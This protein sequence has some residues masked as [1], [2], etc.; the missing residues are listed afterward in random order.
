[1]TDTA[2]TEI[3]PGQSLAGGTVVASIY[4]NDTDYP[5]TLMLVLLLMPTPGAYYRV[6]D[7]WVP[8]RA[9]ENVRDHPNIVPAVADY[10]ANGGDY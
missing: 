6:A 2:A 3:L 10:V 7:V 5:E 1:M 8:S 9:V 4:V